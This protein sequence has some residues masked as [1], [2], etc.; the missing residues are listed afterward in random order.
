[1]WQGIIGHDAI[2]ERFRLTL[3]SNRLASTYLFVGPAGIGKKMFA[4]ELAHALLCTSSP[5]ISLQPCGQ[6]ESCRLFATGN[7]P[8]LDVV[9]MPADKSTLPIDLFIGDKNHRNQEGLCHRLGTKPFFGRRKVAIVDDAD[10]FNVNS[11]NCLLKTLEEPPPSALL[12]LIGTS[13]S[14]QLPTIRSRSQVVRFGP[15]EEQTIANLL[16]EMDVVSDQAFARRIAG[17]SEG[18]VERARQLADTALWEFRDQL[19]TALDTNRFDSARLA[20]AIQTFVDDA[21][22]ES[23]R[24]RGRLRTII[25]FAVAYY[26]ARLREHHSV[27]A[28]IAAIDA[29]LAAF[30]YIDR[31]A[32]VGLV[33]Q[34]WCESLDRARTAR[35]T[36]GSILAPVL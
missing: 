10:H 13:P 18:S 32:N 36:T 4:R 1:M 35:Q 24:K 22:K 23:P 5:E 14:R 19:F 11:A 30:E 6:C 16:L 20:R 27:A 2:V 25:E 33:V 28:S 7:H 12:I 29:S 8:D 15:L 34:W 3:R 17:L 21:G 9:G 31:N 26:R